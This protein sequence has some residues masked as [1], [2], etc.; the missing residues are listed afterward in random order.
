MSSSSSFNALPHLFSPQIIDANTAWAETPALL[1]ARLAVIQADYTSTVSQ[2]ATSTGL[3]V[4]TGT[5]ATVTLTSVPDSIA[6]PSPVTIASG[7]SSAPTT[8]TTTM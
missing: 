6:T 5:E 3:P 2:T 1:Q 7:S 8:S 4:F